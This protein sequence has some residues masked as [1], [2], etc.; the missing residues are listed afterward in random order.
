MIEIW[1]KNIW[2]QE[3]IFVTWF[4][5]IILVKI[6]TTTHWKIQKLSNQIW[7]ISTW[8]H[9]SIA[10]IFS[11]RILIDT[12]DNESLKKSYYEKIRSNFEML[13]LRY[14]VLSIFFYFLKYNSELIEMISIFIKFKISWLKITIEETDAKLSILNLEWRY[15][16]SESRMRKKN[17]I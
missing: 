13:I 12:S 4:F 8:Q 17:I 7:Q 6:D 9:K 14:I 10:L 1:I 5:S 3:H 2:C 11:F 15:Q 16:V